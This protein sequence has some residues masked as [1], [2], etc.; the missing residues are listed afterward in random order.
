MAARK[1][2]VAVFGGSQGSELALALG[3][4]LR[5]R[6]CITL[7]GG[8]GLPETLVKEQA[9]R[10]ARPGP[11]IG[12]V[13]HP[14]RRQVQPVDSGLLI[15]TDLDH[16]RN[17][18]NAHLCDAA[19]CLKGGD[20]TTS[21]LIFSL[22]LHRPVA[23]VGDWLDP[24][25]DD[26]LCQLLQQAWRRVPDPPGGREAIVQGLATGAPL[27]RFGW[28]DGATAIVAWVLSQVTAAERKGWVAALAGYEDMVRQ[29]EQ[30]CRQL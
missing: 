5:R 4:E 25:C 21:E 29:V 10:G 18:L 19:I 8:Q 3:A 11:W 13:R 22:A 14:R 23:L 28:N 6:S 30:W 15:H 1:P 24:S 16:R 2:I 27:R 12:V 9:I 17:Y 20:G 7:S 26:G